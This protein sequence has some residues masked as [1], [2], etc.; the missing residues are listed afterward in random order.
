L[1]CHPA[2][3]TIPSIAMMGIICWEDRSILLVKASVCAVSFAIEGRVTFG[4]FYNWL[5]VCQE[6]DAHLVQ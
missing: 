1:R 4:P 6:R 5:V 2:F 3:N